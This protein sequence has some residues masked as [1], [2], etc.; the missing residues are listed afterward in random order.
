MRVL[1]CG[2]TV[3]HGCEFCEQFGLCSTCSKKSKKT[4]K[5]H[6]DICIMD[7]GISDIE[8]DSDDE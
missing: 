4:L 2:V 7:T 3:V 5:D 8:S 6:E 1:Q